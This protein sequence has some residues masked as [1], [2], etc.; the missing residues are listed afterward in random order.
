MKLYGA[1]RIQVRHC[2]YYCCGGELHKI[3][4]TSHDP[5]EARRAAK[6]HERQLAKKEIDNYANQF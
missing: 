3:P 2:K 1:K 4:N 6:K 5:S